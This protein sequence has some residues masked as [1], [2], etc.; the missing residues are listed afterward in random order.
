MEVKQEE[1]APVDKEATLVEARV[2]DS[3][4]DRSPPIL[5]K[6]E[7]VPGPGQQP[8]DGD[9][10]DQQVGSLSGL[11]REP[12]VKK[13]IETTSRRL[14]RRK[15]EKRRHKTKPPVLRLR[16]GA[17][18]DEEAAAELFP[19]QPSSSLS[20]EIKAAILEIQIEMAD[21]TK[22]KEA[23]KKKKKKK[24]FLDKVTCRIPNGSLT[25]IPTIEKLILFLGLPLQVQQSLG[26]GNCGPSSIILQL[27]LVHDRSALEDYLVAG[28]PND[29]EDIKRLR[30]LL[31]EVMIGEGEQFVREFRQNW[32][33]HNQWVKEG[34]WKSWAF[35]WERM[36]KLVV[37]GESEWFNQ[38][39]MAACALLLKRD[40]YMLTLN[41][42]PWTPF[43][44]FSGNRVDQN[45]LTERTPLFIGF[46]GSI[47]NQDHFVSLVPTSAA[48]LASL[49]NIVMQHKIWADSSP[50]VTE[51]PAEIEEPQPGR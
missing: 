51:Q 5:L 3:P 14:K 7:E 48:S 45:I 31:Q 13:K 18:E 35:L 11:W 2:P 22:E 32:E 43:E 27:R 23:K 42:H 36:G 47:H 17:G 29:L 44:K 10:V 12:N 4:K 20:D 24:C 46:T 41:S 38:D 39:A 40:V 26:K 50:K 30:T 21:R 16:G 28:D 6:R 15:K 25:R 34:S 8:S 1:K 9:P 37:G 19:L 33:L 49:R